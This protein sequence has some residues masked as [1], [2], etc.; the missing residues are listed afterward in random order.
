M[1]KL[2]SY[3]IPTILLL[4]TIL[5]A[6]GKN[7]TGHHPFSGST[8]G[9]GFNLHVIIHTQLFNHLLYSVAYEEPH[10]IIFKGQKEL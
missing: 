6:A 7:P 1:K 8:E 2:T 10:K 3:T 4:A 5:W 9:D